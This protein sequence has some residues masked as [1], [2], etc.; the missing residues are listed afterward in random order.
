MLYSTRN[1]QKPKWTENASCIN[2]SLETP[3]EVFV[4]RANHISPPSSN[5]WPGQ[6][7]A[8]GCKVGKSAVH[9]GGP[10]NPVKIIPIPPLTETPMIPQRT[11]LP[12]PGLQD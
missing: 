10:V 7:P 1:T 3:I 5:T 2:Y 8:E 11:K 12:T 9:A 6:R 4:V